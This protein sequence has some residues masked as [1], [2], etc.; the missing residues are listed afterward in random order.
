MESD[1]DLKNQTIDDQKKYQNVT[2]NSNTPL[3]ETKKEEKSSLDDEN[4]E[5]T[6][7]K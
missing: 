6:I 4:P 2:M 1:Q 7:G 5:N 3:D